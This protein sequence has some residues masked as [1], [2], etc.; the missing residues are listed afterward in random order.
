[1]NGHGEERGKEKKRNWAVEP[2]L[3][4]HVCIY[5][6]LRSLI[7]FEFVPLFTERILTAF[8]MHIL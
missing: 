5:L 2:E 8:G 1:M 3:K 7:L 4:T 6:S